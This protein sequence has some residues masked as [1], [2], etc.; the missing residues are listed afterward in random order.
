M[1]A[2]RTHCSGAR[3][4]SV[5]VWGSLNERPSFPKGRWVSPTCMSN[6]AEWWIRS[7]FPLRKR[8]KGRA[9]QDRGEGLGDSHRFRHHW[10]NN[11]MA[12]E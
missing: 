10:A 8:N 7:V 2:S 3:R 9:D 12:Q 1:E 11:R 4:A 5:A 6:G